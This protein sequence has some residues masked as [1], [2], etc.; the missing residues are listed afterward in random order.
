M[1][2]AEIE[3]EIKLWKACYLPRE[4]DGA[5][6]SQSNNT[7]KT[8]QGFARRLSTPLRK[9]FAGQSLGQPGSLSP[10]QESH[11]I[12]PKSDDFPESYT[13]VLFSKVLTVE[14]FSSAVQA[15]HKLLKRFLEHVRDHV[16]S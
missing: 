9:V 4:R 10:S 6:N 3:N 1:Q 16:V 12:H 13:P 11:F 8:M 15:A 14:R 7:C 2:T 5:A